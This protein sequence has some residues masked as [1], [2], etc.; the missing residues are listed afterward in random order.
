METSRLYEA[1]ALEL[2]SDDKEYTK[3]AVENIGKTLNKILDDNKWT[4]AKLMEYLDTDIYKSPEALSRILNHTPGRQPS[5]A[6]FIEL[7]R[8][9]G[10]DL[11]EVADCG[12]HLFEIGKLSDAHLLEMLHQISEELLRRKRQE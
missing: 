1:F 7:R 12:E 10:V 8:V 11:N 6:Q 5:A 9:F 3:K 4:N 2:F